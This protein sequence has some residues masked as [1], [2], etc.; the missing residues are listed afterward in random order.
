[1][2]VAAAEI[3]ILG[4]IN[5]DVLARL[6]RPLAPG[7]DNLV[8]AVDVRLGGVGANAAVA[9]AK[10]GLRP[11]LVTSVGNDPF[12]QFALAALEQCNVDVSLVIRTDGVT[13]IFA[14]PIDPGGQRTIVGSG[15][16]NG[17]R[18]AGEPWQ[19]LE[20]VRAAH[21]VG[22]TLLSPATRDLPMQIAKEARRRGITV[23]FDPG[24]DPAKRARE[25]ILALLPH[26]DTLFVSP[27][28]AEA[29]TGQ[30]GAAALEGIAR[31]GAREV[32]LKRGEGG[33]QFLQSGR[34]WALPPF[35]VQA[36]DCTGAGD[37]FAAGYIAAKLRGWETADAALLAN[38]LGAAA[39]ATLGAGENMPGPAQ[40]LRLL[41]ADP[42]SPAPS[43]LAARLL[44]LLQG[45]GAGLLDPPAFWARLEQQSGPV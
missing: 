19:W 8:P 41:E 30:Q 28:E 12:G 45:V 42:A 27:E 10:W 15:G 29:L 21:L 18:P 13:G 34:W 1:M 16:A 36:V 22:Y 6:A 7:T 37:A 23:S 20:G 14:I 26:L 32:I 31:C 35:A 4:D 44:R 2:T 40:V 38:A 43:K 24:P 3:L 25:E 33:C 11:R 39:A 17:L 9:L 5:V